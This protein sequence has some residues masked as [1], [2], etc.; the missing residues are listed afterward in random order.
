MGA[1]AGLDG[2]DGGCGVFL[3]LADGGV[4]GGWGLGRDVL[5][6]GAEGL[7]GLGL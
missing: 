5:W 4:C 1:G 3:A 7:W 2:R 6:G